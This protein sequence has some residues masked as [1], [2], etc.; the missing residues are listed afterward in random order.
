MSW[1]VSFESV[2]TAIVKF[3]SKSSMVLDRIVALA[4]ILI[5]CSEHLTMFALSFH[6]FVVLCVMSGWVMG[7]PCGYLFVLGDGRSDGI[8][9]IQGCVCVYRGDRL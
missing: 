7:G 2:S 8:S 4:C 5:N 6:R 9:K 1:D 3:F